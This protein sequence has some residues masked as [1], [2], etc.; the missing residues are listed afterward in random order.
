M[1]QFDG[2]LFVYFCFY[3]LLLV[4]SKKLL[5]YPTSWRFSLMFSCRGLAILGLIFSLVNPFWLNF[6]YGWCKIKVQYH[7]F[8]GGYPVYPTL[9][10]EEIVLSQLSAFG[11]LVED[12]SANT[13]GFISGSLFCFI[14]PYVCLY[15]GTT[16]FHY[17]FF[18]VNFGVPWDL[19]WLL[20]WIFLF[21][22]KLSLGYWW[23]LHS[24]SRLLWVLLSY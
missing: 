7:S 14:G 1:F 8:A 22:K 13:W 4:S 11:I 18:A 5:P 16:L 21:Q 2:G 12:H 24:I 23:R 20:G 10:F 3:C 6:T 17:C 15:A 19:L 9:F